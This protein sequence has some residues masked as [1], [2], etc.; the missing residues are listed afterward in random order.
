MRVNKKVGNTGGWIQEG[1]L[2]ELIDLEDTPPKAY[3]LELEVL[4]EDQFLTIINKPAGITVSGNQ[5]RT[6]QNALISNVSISTDKDA[7]KWP[8]PV[9]RLDNQTSGIL[10]VAK[11]R[12]ALMSLGQLFENN[13]V[14]KKYNA[15]VMGKTKSEGV[16]DILIDNQLAVTK[17][18]TIET[19]PSLQSDWLSLL[20]LKPETGRT[21]QLRIHCS[22]NGFPILGDKLYGNEG[23]ILKHK[24]LF[25]VASGIS[26]NH[27]T[28]NSLVEIDLE[29][30]Y[31]FTSLLLREK[32]RWNKFN[33][34]KKR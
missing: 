32:K 5:Y 33:S 10:V 26:F 27:P 20:E 28:T 1:Q 3:D 17:Y 16:I 11:T 12:K 8:R 6:I 19:L 4:Y 9:H 7:L 18:K 21:H 31:K 14:E 13:L 2:I 15:I 34:S 25:L 24:G 30:P 22:N 23:N 29:L